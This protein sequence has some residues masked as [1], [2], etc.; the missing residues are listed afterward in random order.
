M[1]LKVI[2]TKAE[3]VISAPSPKSDSK[4]FGI[5]LGLNMELYKKAHIASFA[6]NDGNLDK[7]MNTA[8][9]YYLK[10]HGIMD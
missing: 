3:K 8:I 10:K 2:N 6:L 9:E 4:T 5:S 1:A 7:T